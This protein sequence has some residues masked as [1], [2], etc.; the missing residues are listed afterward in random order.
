VQIKLLYITILI[1]SI[2]LYAQSV[3]PEIYEENGL[4]GYRDQDNLIIIK[5][6]FTAALEFNEAGIAAVADSSGWMYIDKTGHILLRPFIY[7]NGPDYYVEGLARYVDNGKI[8]FF[9]QSGKI[10]IKARWDFAY[11]FHNGKAAVCSGCSEFSKGEYHSIKGG[12]WGYIDT[13]G[14]LIDSLGT[15]NP[16]SVNKGVN[17]LKF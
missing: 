17:L 12:K 7:D 5:A 3:Q 8:G 1:V 13:A 14:Q 10:V 15:V 4:F 6:Q 2:G 11:P 16:D 9:D